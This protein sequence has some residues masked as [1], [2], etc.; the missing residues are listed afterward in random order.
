MHPPSPRSSGQNWLVTKQPLVLLLSHLYR[1]LFV[2][3][4]LWQGNLRRGK[5]YS[6]SVFLFPASALE[7]ALYQTSHPAPSSSTRRKEPAFTY[8]YTHKYTHTYAQ[9]HTHV[10]IIKYASVFMIENFPVAQT[11]LSSN[12]YKYPLIH[13]PHSVFSCP[14]RLVTETAKERDRGCVRRSDICSRDHKKHID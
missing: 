14:K 6:R 13:R 1:A 9:T 7:L 8:T 10:C 12:V 11:F 2:P 5:L 3:S 4:P